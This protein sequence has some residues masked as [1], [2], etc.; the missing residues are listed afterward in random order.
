M[1]ALAVVAQSLG[2]TCM[3]WQAL[4]WNTPALNFYDKIGAKVD[5]GHYSLMARDLVR[6]GFVVAIPN[7][8]SLFG[9]NMPQQRTFDKIAAGLKEASSLSSSPLFGKVNTDSL[10]LIGHSLGGVASLRIMDSKCALPTCTGRY[11]KPLELKAV[12][13]YGSNT[14]TP[15]IGTYAKINTR[16]VPLMF[17]QGNL[18][19][20]ATLEDGLKT[21]KEKITGSP[22]AFLTLDGANHYSINNTNNPPGAAADKKNP[23]IDRD[24]GIKTIATWSKAFASST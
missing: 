14:K 2:C 7:N 23:S 21:F 3:K 16:G 5:K 24:E 1:K 18:D 17:I 11:E 12:I 6:G 8:K 9:R 13:V 10:A 4:D 15:L 22:V 20:T 19:G